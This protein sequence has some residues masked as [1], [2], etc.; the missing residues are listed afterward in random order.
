MPVN[1][2]RFLQLSAIGIA[3]GVADLGCGEQNQEPLD[4]PGLLAILGPQR[5]RELGAGYRAQNPAERD[6]DTLRGKISEASGSGIF[7]KSVGDAIEDDFANGRTVVVDGWVLA[8]TEA[9]Q[10]ALFALSRP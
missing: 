7:H 1:R 10:A 8:V 5:V 2:R 4:Q 9:R 6:A 3:A